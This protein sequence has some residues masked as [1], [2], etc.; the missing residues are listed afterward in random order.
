MR[1]RTTVVTAACLLL[2]SCS[3]SSPTPRAD[4]PS[5]RA[6]SAIFTEIQE[7]CDP[8]A[9]RYRALENARRGAESKRAS[10]RL[11]AA[12]H[13]L[14]A[15]LRE[16][17]APP[18][19]EPRLDVYADVLDEY[20]RAVVAAAKRGSSPRR[21]L[22]LVVR[23]ARIGVRLKETAVAAGMPQPCPPTTD[24]Q[25]TLVVA[26]SNFDCWR[27][28][29]HVRAEI[30]SLPDV[31]IIDIVMARRVSAS[32]RKAITR[33]TG[34][35]GGAQFYKDIARLE[36]KRERLLVAI[37]KAY[38]AR[39]PVAGTA[40]VEK[41]VDV[42]VKADTKL[43]RGGFTECAKAFQVALRRRA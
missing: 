16:L 28:T 8:M 29:R 42:A 3:D 36:E 30:Q 43:I 33:A 34:P 18:G 15:G 7:L 1:G 31:P 22:R 13:S 23:A 19:V 41:L 38:V 39:E 35:Q 4:P 10:K 12:E 5:A 25:S 37:E 27:F 9:K 32:V 14:A 20:R 11:T 26:E 21:S 2:A 40:L 6:P 17:E 24:V